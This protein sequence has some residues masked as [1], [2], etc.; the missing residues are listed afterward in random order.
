MLASILATSAGK[1]LQLV[2][3]STEY[4]AAGP[5]SKDETA[6]QAM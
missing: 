1:L 6:C 4:S 5:K 2:L 3:R